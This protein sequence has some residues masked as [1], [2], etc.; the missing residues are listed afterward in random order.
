MPLKGSEQ[1]YRPHVGQGQLGGKRDPQG[2]DQGKG[3]G[4]RVKE[5]VAADPGEA[6]AV[7]QGCGCFPDGEVVGVEESGV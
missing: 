4:Y 5:Q 3:Y 2:Y 1:L 6:V 7:A